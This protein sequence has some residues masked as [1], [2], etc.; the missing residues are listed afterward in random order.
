MP[1]PMLDWLRDAIYTF[2]TEGLPPNALQVYRLFGHERISQPFRFEITLIAESASIDLHARIGQ[3]ATLTIS[4]LTPIGVAYKRTIFGRI[5]RFLQLSAGPRYSQYQAILSPTLFPLSYTRNSR[6]FRELSTVDI[7]EKVLTEGHVSKD[8]IQTLLHGDYGRRDFCV[9]YQESDLGFICRLLEEEGIFYFFRHE[10]GRDILVLGDGSHA[11]EAAAH[12]SHL[13]YREHPHRYEEVIHSLCAEARFRPGSTVLRDFRFKHPNLDM[14]AKQAARDFADY[15]VY[16]FPGEYVDLELGQ[17]LAKVRHEEIQGE[18]SLISAKSNCPALS[19][20]HTFVLDGLW[21]HDYASGYLVVEVQH[22]GIQPQVLGEEHIGVAEAQYKN[23]ILC[24]PSDVNY[25]PPRIT[26]R[27]CILGVQ[28]ATVVGPSDEEIHCDE[29]GRIKVLFHWDRQ[30]QRNDESSCW[31]RVSQPW[32]GAGYGGMFIPRVGQEVLVQFLEGDPDRPIIV[33]RVYNGINMMPH[34]LPEK[35]NISAIRT[36]ST[37]GGEGFNEIRM[38][39]TANHEE[40][41]IHAQK[42]QNEVVRNNRTRRVGKNEKVRITR[43]QS[44]SIG[45]SRRAF[46][47]HNDTTSIGRDSWTDVGNDHRMMVINN[48]L[49]AA[50]TILLQA[51]QSLKLECN[52]GYILIDEKGEIHIQGPM[53]YINCE[54]PSEPHWLQLQVVDED[55]APIT[56]ADVELEIEGKKL[57]HTTDAQGKVVLKGLKRSEVAITLLGHPFKKRS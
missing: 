6:V 44:A 27:P 23:A 7:V 14:E 53:V 35:K 11:I 41:F 43:Y 50:R 3:P 49:T 45:R 20:G 51:S 15:Q 12:A 52:G 38:N 13:V 47:R 5:E 21:R 57:K 31:I 9:Q 30:G 10:D 24:I 46:I 26:P 1:L 28:S 18:R 36:A 32:G 17:R 34:E 29:Y 19:P 39:D 33:G 16:Y 4:G 48:S 42:N 40:L 2:N 8:Q 25:R 37:P 22:E 55:G 54:K 56:E